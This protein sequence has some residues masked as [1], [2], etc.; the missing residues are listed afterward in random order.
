MITTF[1]LYL[2]SEIHGKPVFKL[3]EETKVVIASHPL[4]MYCEAQG[5]PPISYIWKK[6]G[7][8]LT[9]DKYDKRKLEYK[10]RDARPSDSGDYFCIASN[11]YGNRTKKFDVNVQETVRSKP[12][13][14]P[15]YPKNTIAHIGENASLDCFELFSRTMG[16]IPDFRWY[17]STKKPRI[18]VLSSNESEF[19]A[20]KSRRDTKQISAFF[21]EN[22][23]RVQNG[24]KL[25][26]IR[27]NIHNVSK[28]DDGYYTCSGCNH[29]GC[30]LQ[31]AR[32][33]IIENLGK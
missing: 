8:I 10:I 7:K 31:C 14:L 32:L 29:L 4:K 16:T 2:L 25:E 17:L 6:D 9:P 15:A 13:L 30:A 12:Y 33:T 21:H 1:V 11:K 19:K 20:W 3:A 24:N 23:K 26:G 28:S 18:E 5:T 22:I 27:L